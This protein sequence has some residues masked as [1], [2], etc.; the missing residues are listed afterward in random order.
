MFIQ[1]QNMGNLCK[2]LENRFYPI[3]GKSLWSS[4]LVV[5]AY[6]KCG[7]KSYISFEKVI[8]FKQNYL[9]PKFKKTF[10]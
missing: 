7:N 10:F 6:E 8:W 4:K 2:M 5:Y 1:A 3:K 9:R